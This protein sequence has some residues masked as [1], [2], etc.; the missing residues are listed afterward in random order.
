MSQ[1]VEVETQ[2]E[3]ESLARLHPKR[4]TG[5]QAYFDEVKRIFVV[6]SA[7]VVIGVF[8]D[9]INP[10]LHLLPRLGSAWNLFPKHECIGKLRHYG[11]LNIFCERTASY[12]EINPGHCRAGPPCLAL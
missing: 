3:Q 11:V 12:C 7:A 6:R 2:S 5:G 10:A 9:F 4:A 8:G 1:A